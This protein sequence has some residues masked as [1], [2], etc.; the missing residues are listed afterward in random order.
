MS[1]IFVGLLSK[2]NTTNGHSDSDII[3]NETTH[4]AL[5][6]EIEISQD[7]TLDDLKIQILTLDALDDLSVPTPDFLRVRLLEN[8]RLM[9]V[10]R[11]KDQTL[12]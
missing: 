6:G 1:L 9:R 10:L 12:R 2:E 5:L 7:A 3:S 8:K 11:E 4:G